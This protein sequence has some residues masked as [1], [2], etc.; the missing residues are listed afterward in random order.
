MA[1]RSVCLM[2]IAISGA[3]DECCVARFL[4]GLGQLGVKTGSAPGRAQDF[5]FAPKTRPLRV[6][7]YTPCG[8]L[9]TFPNAIMLVQFAG[10][11]SLG[12]ALGALGT[13]ISAWINGDRR[14]A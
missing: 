8:R 9:K 5:R 10:G 11:F 13:Y 4:S 3:V 12:F 7:E 1:D 14:V 2:T 6:N